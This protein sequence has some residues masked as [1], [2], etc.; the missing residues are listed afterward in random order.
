MFNNLQVTCLKYSMLPPVIGLV[1]Q[2]VSMNLMPGF[3]RHRLHLRFG[4]S[5][6]SS[7]LTNEVILNDVIGYRILDWWDP[8][9]PYHDTSFLTDIWESDSD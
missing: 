2:T 3:R 1:L 8:L 6:F 7:T 5:I 4:T 9:Y